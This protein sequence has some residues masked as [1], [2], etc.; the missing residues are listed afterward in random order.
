MANYHKFQIGDLVAYKHRP[1]ANYL[2]GKDYGFV[3]DIVRGYDA[4]TWYKIHWAEN[5]VRARLTSYSHTQLDL[6]A[7]GKKTQA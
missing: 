4:Q 1:P 2:F 5:H 3:T 7:R 6:I